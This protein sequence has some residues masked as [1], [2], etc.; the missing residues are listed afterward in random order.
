[1]LN[2]GE[3]KMIQRERKLLKHNTQDIE[4]SLLNNEEEEHNRAWLLVT[5]A[6]KT[7]LV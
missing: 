6:I 1:M 3:R 2:L 5:Q 4:A 7:Y